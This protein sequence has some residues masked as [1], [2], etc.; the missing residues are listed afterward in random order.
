MK[1]LLASPL[2]G[3]V[4]TA[5]TQR[6]GG[7][8]LSEVARA[9]VAGPSSVQRA[10]D[11]L[12]EAGLVTRHDGARPRFE[13]TDDPA[14]EPLLS[15]VRA[16]TPSEGHIG[17]IARANPGVEFASIDEDGVLL[18]ISWNADTEALVRLERATRGLALP[19]TTIDHDE[20]RGRLPNE[21]E[22]RDRTAGAT[23]LK[24][25]V[26]RSFPDAMRRGHLPVTSLGR[27]NPQLKKP[28]RRAVADIARRFGLRRVAVFGSAVRMDLRP[29]SDVDVLIEPRPD[30]QLSIRE[31]AGLR[32]RL[33][34]LFDRDV[35]VVN[36]RF[37]RSEM[38][39]RAEQEAVVLYGRP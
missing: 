17:V 36:A 15:L 13:L 26:A 7:L 4:A 8:G 28:S 31:H 10:L 30:V 23:I 19:V 5:L 34:E 27:L 38:L 9:V 37:A 21:P 12:L 16:V 14:T 35:D 29:D 32:T 11:V 1:S 18:V 2:G 22:L 6:A 39:R 24:G 25:T 20:L 33:E 3:L